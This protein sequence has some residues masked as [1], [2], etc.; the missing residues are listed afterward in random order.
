MRDPHALRVTQHATLWVANHEVVA[1]FPSAL[2]CRGSRQHALAVLERAAFR[3]L[4]D[5]ANLSRGLIRLVN[6]LPNAS[7]CIAQI[8]TVWQFFAHPTTRSGD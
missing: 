7:L 4:H 1:V 5:P 8:L 3:V 6:W 2:A